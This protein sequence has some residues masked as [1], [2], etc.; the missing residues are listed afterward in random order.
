M[1]L[2]GHSCPIPASETW[3]IMSDDT[4]AINCLGPM[5]CIKCGAPEYLKAY[6]GRLPGHCFPAFEM[7][8]KYS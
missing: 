3:V 1:T 6:L 5:S 4:S 8:L 7:C 2:T